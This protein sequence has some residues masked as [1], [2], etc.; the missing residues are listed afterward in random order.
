MNFKVLCLLLVS[1]SVYNAVYASASSKSIIDAGVSILK[2][3][4]GGQSSSNSDSSESNEQSLSSNP[5]D[6]LLPSLSS[7]DWSKV[8]ASL[9]K[10]SN[11]P[12]ISSSLTP[13][14]Q[15]SIQLARNLTVRALG[16]TSD[17]TNAI[18]H[19][20][21]NAIRDAR[22]V[23]ALYALS[24]TILK[25]FAKVAANTPEGTSLLVI[26]DGLAIVAIIAKAL[27][28]IILAALASG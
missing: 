12:N 22:P 11:V 16:G 24:N 2:G 15:E 26:Q 10:I 21:A 19:A 17:L 13:A 8:N 23:Q 25:I 4:L 7:V 14:I 20:T 5:L 28:P 6:K 9:L 3:V 1:V 18:Q 27:T